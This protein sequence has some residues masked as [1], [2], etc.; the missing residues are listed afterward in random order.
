MNPP[1][2]L[3]V[4]GVFYRFNDG[5][6]EYLVEKRK[7]DEEHYKNQIA[8]P[9]GHLKKGFEPVHTG[10]KRE[11]REEIKTEDGTGIRLLNYFC[12]GNFY[13]EKDGCRALAF[14]IKDWIGD[15]HH[16]D[17]GECLYW[18]DS[19]DDLSLK[20]GKDVITKLEE[21]LGR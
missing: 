11:M 15:I 18:A 5:K 1:D 4:V 14:A 10:I 9:G 21:V 2:K 16:T 17:E 3:I 6:L 8:L 13:Y 7:D 20:L 19:K 12:L